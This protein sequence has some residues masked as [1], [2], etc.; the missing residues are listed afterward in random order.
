MKDQVRGRRG[1]MGAGE[2]V[3]HCAR[4]DTFGHGEAEHIAH[5]PG[6][7][8]MGGYLCMEL[9]RAREQSEKTKQKGGGEKKERKK[10][11]LEHG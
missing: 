9:G 2:V 8:H 7:V 5:I 4:K 1:G 6:K 11:G 3:T 10:E